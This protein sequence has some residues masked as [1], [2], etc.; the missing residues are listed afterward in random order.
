MKQVTLEIDDAIF[1]SA[2][3]KARQAGTSLSAVVID[4]LRQFSGGGESEFEQLEIRE[5][6]L[7]QQLQKRGASFSGGDRLTRDELYERHAVP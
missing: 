7:R 3:R 4:F 6:S 1:H 5:E 2:A